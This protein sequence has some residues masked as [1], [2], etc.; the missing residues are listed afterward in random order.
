MLSCLQ[1]RDRG[2]VHAQQLGQGRLGQ[3]VLS[4]VLHHADSD[5][6]S[7]PRPL[8]LTAI[9]QG[10]TH[11][12]LV[13]GTSG[14]FVSHRHH[15]PSSSLAFLPFGQALSRIL[16]GSLELTRIRLAVR[17]DRS[18][19]EF[20]N[21]YSRVDRPPRAVAPPRPQFPPGAF[22]TFDG[23]NAALANRR[24]SPPAFP[25]HAEWPLALMQAASST[26]P[27][28]PEGRR[29]ATWTQYNTHVI[30][31]QNGLAGHASLA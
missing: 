4:A 13:D 23:R 24:P 3:A 19:L 11:V 5:L 8:V 26:R 25:R 2:L 14:E 12:A 15:L 9:L 10:L 22:N 17:R 27:L 21:T 30:K 31:Q 18:D 6:V 28:Q 7:K 29:R 20:V 16:A 1:P